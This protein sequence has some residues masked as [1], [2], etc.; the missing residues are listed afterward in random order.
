[1]L[2]EVPLNEL[3]EQWNTWFSNRQKELS[4]YANTTGSN[5]N[6]IANIN[7]ITEL[8]EGLK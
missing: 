6:Y 8:L 2:A 3:M 4:K 7:G 5:G 1:M